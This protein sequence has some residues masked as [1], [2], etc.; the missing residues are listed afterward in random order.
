MLYWS[1]LILQYTPRHYTNCSG[2]YC[3]GGLGFARS[4]R[5]ALPDICSARFWTVTKLSK[6]KAEAKTINTEIYVLNPQRKSRYLLEITGSQA[7]GLDRN[8][9][10]FAGACKA[11][12]LE[13]SSPRCFSRQFH[14]KGPCFYGHP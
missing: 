12:K 8:A 10:I 6:F 9:R 13:P 11:L 14:Y 4:F 3:G 5:V 2:L 7:F 1:I